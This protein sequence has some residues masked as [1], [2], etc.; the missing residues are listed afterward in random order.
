[1]L[2]VSGAVARGTDLCKEQGRRR[3]AEEVGASDNRQSKQRSTLSQVQGAS[4]Q[5]FI[6][7]VSRL[8]MTLSGSGRVTISIN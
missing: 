4:A 1:V 7:V 6:V 8:T 2:L 3:T 5:R